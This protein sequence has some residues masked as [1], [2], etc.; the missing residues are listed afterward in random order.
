MEILRTLL[1][2]WIIMMIVLMQLSSNVEGRHHNHKISKK[3]NHK[4]SPVSI[5]P[6]Y[7][8]SPG[9][10][11][12]ADENSPPPQPPDVVPSDPIDL[13]PGNS[14]T[15]SE[16]C[17][18]DVRDY[19]AAGDGETD[20]TAA[21]R[22]AWKAACQVES[23][24]ILVPAEHTFMITSTI[25]SG[26]CQPGLVLQVDGVLMPPNGP[27]C[28]PKADSDKQWLVF[29]RLNNMTL[30]GTG[31]IEGNG[32][33]WW[34]LPCKPHRGPNGST[35]PGP[36]NSPAM[37][38][39]FMSTNLAVTNIRIQNSPQFHMKFDGCEGVFIE[40]LSI[41]SPKLSPNT[42]GIHIENTKSVGI[43]NSVI[44]NGIISL[45]LIIIRFEL[46]TNNECATI[47]HDKYL[48]NK[49]FG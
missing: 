6:A 44:G 32:D 5:V 47:M 2:L 38:R 16:D 41:S 12:N 20:D 34:E 42:D 8:P 15:T 24:V 40:R 27:D 22:A 39:F 48:S 7:A 45:S 33:K 1:S 29:Y 43:Y 28:W 37:I 23:A 21:F 4:S 13:P 36:C 46:N 14:P 26:P 49:R 31:V 19:G 17:A 18:F 3:Q 35:L 9:D 30:T 11:A 10:N 25:F